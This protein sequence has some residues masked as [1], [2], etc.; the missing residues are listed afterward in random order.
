MTAEGAAFSVMV[1][2]GEAYVPAFALALGLGEAFA[3]MVATAPL[4]VGGCLQLVTPAAVRRL[5]SH[6]RWVVMAAALQAAAFVPLVYAALVG[7]GTPLLVFLAASLY[8][9]GGMATSPA[10]NT[11]VEDLVPRRIRARYFARRGRAQQAS[12]FLGLTLAGLVLESVGA[13]GALRGFALLFAVACLARVVS[14]ALLARLREPVPHLEEAR[15][16]SPV[17]FARRLRGTRDGHVLAMLLSV[18][19]AVNVAAPYFTPYMLSEL[20]L[21]Y[22]EFTALVAAAFVARVVALPA[23]GLAARRLGTRRLMWLGAAGIAP[24]PALWLV[25]DAF[26]WLLV[27]QLVS[28]VAWGA[29]EL[30]ATLSFFDGIPRPERTSTLTLFNLANALA[31]SVGALAGALLWRWHPED[32]DI[33]V[34]L[35]LVSA[36]AR[37]GSL[38]L[39]RSVPAL[40]PTARDVQLRTLAVR[41]AV[42]AIQRPVVATLDSEPG[43][44]AVGERR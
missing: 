44:K 38:V 36:V 12:L 19:L 24:L 41:P 15:R 3:G 21:S 13:E 23:L 40:P 11:W 20:R 22:A 6:R 9:G 43:E 30:C 8:W 7:A 31:I 26:G 37:V 25:S 28:G 27:V 5:R 42:G 34:L 39:M 1:G 17:E 2:A 14:G 10:W 4:L 18:Q 16:V 35:F 29:F 32:V 33:Y